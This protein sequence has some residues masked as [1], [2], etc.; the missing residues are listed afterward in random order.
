MAIAIDDAA[1]R[2]GKIAHPIRVHE[3]LILPRSLLLLIRPAA[4][5]RQRLDQGPVGAVRTAEHCR[6]GL[7]DHYEVAGEVEGTGEIRAAAC[8]AGKE[9]RSAA[10]VIYRSCSGSDSVGVVRCAVA[11][12]TKL[13]DVTERPMLAAAHGCRHRECGTQASTRSVTSSASRKGRRGYQLLPRLRYGPG[14]ADSEHAAPPAGQAR[15]P[16]RWLR[17]LAGCGQAAFFGEV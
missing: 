15:S 8:A 10:I 11:H 2:D 12:S 9:Q 13:G 3:R 14:V 6:A 5:P 16:S 17:P 1:S 4:V 7:H